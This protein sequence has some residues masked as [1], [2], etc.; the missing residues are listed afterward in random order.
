MLL[1]ALAPGE[2]LALHHVFGAVL[3]LI[4]AGLIVTG[5]QAVALNTDDLPGYALALLAAFV[6]SS[7]SVLSRRFHTVPT[8]VVTGFCLATAIL[9]AIAHLGLET[10]AWPEGVGQWLAVL[11]LG[12]GPVG[13]AFYVWDIGVKHGDIQVL[14][15]ASYSAPLLSTLVLIGFGMGSFTWATGLA[16]ALITAGAVI[17]AKD[18]LFR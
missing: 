5:G 6:W 7:Y 4:G 12:L 14:G 11:G 16:C 17:A 15:A 1:S 9:A 3:G 10:T 18:M 13:L 2:R 8:D